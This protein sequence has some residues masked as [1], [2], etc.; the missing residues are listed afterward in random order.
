[1]LDVAVSGAALAVSW[2]VLV[3][4]GVAVRTRLGSPILFRQRRPGRNG[5]PFTIYKFRTM[6]DA[7]DAQGALLSDGARLTALGRWLRRTSLDELPELVNVL[8]GEMS[9]VGPRPLLERYR[10]YF[11]PRE[12]SRERVRPGI[13]GLAQIR[14]RN[15]LGWDERLEAD[16][17]YVQSLSILKDL[18]ILEETL[19][20]VVTARGV[21]T[22]STAAMAD[23]DE[24]RRIR[25]A[26]VGAEHAQA[27]VA[28]HRAAFGASE[29]ETTIFAGHG[30]AEYYA[31]VLAAG[32]GHWALGAFAG[33]A[34]VGYV[35]VRD[36]GP[37]SHLNQIA[38]SP[39][40]RGRGVGRALFDAWTARASAH[41]KTWLSLDVRQGAAV[42]QWYRR[43]GFEVRGTTRTWCVDSLAHPEPGVPVRLEESADSSTW[44]QRYGF[45]TVTAWYQGQA[46]AV[47]R[48][49][50]RDLRVDAT[51]PKPALRG[52]CGAARGRR[53]LVFGTETPPLDG[54]T[55][56]H[57]AVRMER[58]VS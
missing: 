17:E 42:A 3:A 37:R 48:V 33:Q 57:T 44:Q 13:T 31:D 14:G 25:I 58:R 56:L 49:G 10:P 18:Q 28:L 26:P 4:V 46:F 8:R 15:R 39:D 51:L 6:T 53:L 22:D 41:R 11:T 35:H 38:V 43:C 32:R 16:A 52:L 29:L 40:A 50:E 19:R 2:P 24:Q 34:L 21:E 9:L 27:L 1:M 7:R 12:R 23:L 54:A 30:V 55:P 47:G 20:A 36:D 45:S 5:R